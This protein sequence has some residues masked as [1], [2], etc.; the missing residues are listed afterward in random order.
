M[1]KK[2][3]G[4]FFS[5]KQDNQSLSLLEEFQFQTLNLSDIDPNEFSKFENIIIF[6]DQG[7][8][9][10]LKNLMENFPNANVILLL[11]HQNLETILKLKKRYF[12][13]HSFWPCSLY[14]I[15]ESILNERSVNSLDQIEK[16]F[17]YLAGQSELIKQTRQKALTF[18]N[19]FQPIL[20]QGPSGS[21]KTHLSRF[22]HL[23]SF[24]KHREWFHLNLSFYKEM[25]RET[26]LWT[27][28][29]SIFEPLIKV[30]DIEIHESFYGILYIEGFSNVDPIMQA[31]LFDWLYQKQSISMSKG[32]KVVLS[33]NEWPT[34]AIQKLSFF[35]EALKIQMFSLDKRKQD[36]QSLIKIFTFKSNVKYGKNVLKG[37]SFFHLAN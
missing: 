33:L 18:A 8:S 5:T 3:V 30:K 26:H 34:P 31:S 14:F 7:D 28:L 36:L 25:G 2:E 1:S 11:K 6:D 13:H 24:R 4:V 12:F 22:I 35:N 10:L 16:Q 20:I 27:T 21:G 23:N 19:A 29:N 32:I 15:R 9:E 17:P 37:F